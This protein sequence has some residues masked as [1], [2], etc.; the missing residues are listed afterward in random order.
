MAAASAHQQETKRSSCKVAACL[1]AIASTCM[2]GCM[3]KTVPASVRAAVGKDSS[4]A[5][6]AV[7]S[8]VLNMLHMQ[9][10]F[11]YVSHAPL[12]AM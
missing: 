8:Q 11:E 4:G 6:H 7:I 12:L 3:D 2:L 5:S 10:Q 1:Q 9:A